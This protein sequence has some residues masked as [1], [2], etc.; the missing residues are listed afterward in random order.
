MLPSLS[1]L[2]H[3][4]GMQAEKC[5]KPLTRPL[6]C[7]RSKTSC[8]CYILLVTMTAT[9][10]ANLKRTLSS[11]DEID[12]SPCCRNCI[13]D[14]NGFCRTAFRLAVVAVK[15]NHH[16]LGGNLES[17]PKQQFP[18]VCSFKG[19]D[20]FDTQHSAG[21]LPIINCVRMRRCDGLFYCQFKL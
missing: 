5:V 19:R 14:D 12:G 18:H 1:R 17:L 10:T 8:R 7:Q 3:M 13:R 21:S 20:P 4:S 2:P 11:S 15:H 9:G 6:Q 16:V